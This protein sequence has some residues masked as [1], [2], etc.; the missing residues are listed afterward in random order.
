LF[1][2]GE[3]AQP[4]AYQ[5]ASV[6]TTLNALY[7]AGG[8]TPRGNFREIVVRRQGE[9]AAR[10]DLYDY[11]LRGDT[12]NDIVLE[13]GDVVFVPPKGKRATIAGAVLRPAVY[14][15]KPGETLYDLINY[16]G[17][18]LAPAALHRARIS[19]ILPPEERQVPGVDR[20]VFD[21][22]LAEVMRDG[23]TAP[24][25]R[26]G[27]DVRIFTVREEVRNVVTLE[28]SVWQ[29]GS[30]GYRPGLRAWDLI[31]MGLGLR[32][33]A[34]LPTAHIV[35]LNLAD[36][37]LSVIPFSLDTT[38]E[39]E[40]R[41]NPELEEFDMVR[42]FP[43]TRFE[44]P[45]R[46]EVRGAVRDPG[47]L[48]R[49]QGMTLR[50]AILRA[51]GLIKETYTGRAF[52]SRLQPDSTRRIIP[53]ALE[54]D[55]LM[56]PLN[57]EVLEDYDVIEVYGLARYLDEFPVTISGEVRDP[58]TER[59]QEGMTL[60]D[61]VIRAGGLKPTADL[62]VEISRLADPG[63]RESGRITKTIKVRLDSTYIV[64]EGSTRFYLGSR[65]WPAPMND[66]DTAAVL[67]LKPYDHVFVRRIPDFEFPRVVHLTGEV[68]YPGSY[69]LERKDERLRDLIQ[70]AGGL[71]QW[72]FPG[73][74]RFYRGGTLVNVDLPGVLKNR[75]HRDNF[76][77][78]P[79]D[80]MFVPEYI[81]VVRV[82][83]AVNS[84]AAV[85][86]LPGA[87]LDYYIQNAGG[88]AHNADK[89]RVHVR[90]ANG[91]ARIK[92]KFLF[93]TVYQPE[94]GPGSVIT[95]PAKPEAEP[96]KPT[97]F[98]AHLAQIAASVVAI[99]AIATR[100]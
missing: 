19:R 31:R 75:R 48:P 32:P 40:P 59:F 64:P 52:I 33:D 26:D 34:Y 85:A 51:G 58:R 99:I 86:Y 7:A 2:I 13:Q 97:E 12:K 3:V 93:F 44:P 91:A 14:E 20:I 22:E 63:E 8:P 36:S 72:A 41:E 30:Y 70:R 67:E 11:L 81:P 76:T 62:T 25:V 94:P 24:E 100:P 27:D 68:R 71:T 73:G 9:I 42:V 50:D 37:T 6:A 60:R 78:Q 35:R 4:G 38:A 98:F 57:D 39:G 49:F 53:V 74:F 47:V 65:D 88:Y 17:G 77:L 43:R 87:G 23:G 16:A 80:S 54:V 29:P 10:L 83:G 95:V 5:L 82:E 1:V 89:G 56:I 46:V 21:V 15:L 61:L 28:G 55:S 66:G 92:G 84:P 69:T 18:L 90:Y 79:G 45:H 96:F